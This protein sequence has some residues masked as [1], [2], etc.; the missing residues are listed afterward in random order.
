MSNVCEKK[1]KDIFKT[2]IDSHSY[3][4]RHRNKLK[5]NFCKNSTSK[6]S[7]HEQGIKLY[8]ALPQYVKDYDVNTFKWTVKRLLCEHSLYEMDEYFCIFNCI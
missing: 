1:N 3:S 8:N 7:F 5:F 4:T 2:K 6:R